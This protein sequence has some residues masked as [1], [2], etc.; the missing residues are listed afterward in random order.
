MSNITIKIVEVEQSTMRL[1]VKAAS[2]RSLRPVDDYD[3]VAFHLTNP[4]L[5]TPE[6][7][8]NAIKDDVAFMVNLRDASEQVIDN[9]NIE[10]WAGYTKVVESAPLVDPVQEGQT[11]PAQSSPEV[12]L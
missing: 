3:A 7:F 4:N 1:L 12:T 10:D 2:E 11:I 6:K 9:V 8:I 5:D